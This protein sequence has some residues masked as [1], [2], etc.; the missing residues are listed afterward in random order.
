MVVLFV[1]AYNSL[2]MEPD[3]TLTYR[4]SGIMPIPDMVLA[5]C[6]LFSTVKSIYVDDASSGITLSFSSH[7]DIL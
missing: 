6:A 5:F 2:C 3:S 7:N 1:L 4:K